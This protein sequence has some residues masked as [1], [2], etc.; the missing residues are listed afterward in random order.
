M[1][2][3]LFRCGHGSH[4]YGTNTPESDYDE[5]V[6]YLPGI[7]TLLLGKKLETYKHRQDALG[8]PVPDNHK[9]PPQGKE[10]EFIPFQKFARD[11]FN[12]QTY[13]IEVA[14]ALSNQ[15]NENVLI[16]RDLINSFLPNDFSPMLGFAM[17]QTFDYVHRGARLKKLQDVVNLIDELI[18]TA[19]SPKSHDHPVPSTPLRLDTLFNGKKLINIVADNLNIEIGNV[20]N[21]EKQIQTLKL[22]GRDYVET[23]DVRQFTASLLK[24]IYNY[25]HRTE[26][27]SISDVDLKS[28]MHAVRIYEQVIELHETKRITFPR[29]NANE[30]IDIKS[31]NTALDKVRYR[32]LTLEHEANELQKKAMPKK[33]EL[34]DDFETWLLFTLWKLYRLR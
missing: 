16:M 27:S 2:N 19:P 26:A 33:A 5:K 3:V 29:K 4:L 1:E 6:I 20:V 17:K 7:E 13:A 28:L 18:L 11:F 23:L 34:D 25:G 24:L 21:G 14:F 30:L 32:L 15:K 31:G 12:G 22:N 8:N 9:M 10:I